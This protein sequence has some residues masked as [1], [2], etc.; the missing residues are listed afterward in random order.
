MENYKKHYCLILIVTFI[1][2]IC[3]YELLDSIRNFN[4]NPSLTL[5]VILVSQ[6]VKLP[7]EVD[8]ATNNIDFKILYNEKRTSLSKARNIGLDYLTEHSIQGDF[9]TFPDDDS[10]FDAHFFENFLKVVKQPNNYLI[11]VYNT[12]TKTLYKKFNIKNRSKLEYRHFK[13]VG[14]PNI[15]IS[16][17]TFKTGVRFDTDLGV[18][19]KYG[20]AE[21]NDFYFRC[22]NVEPFYFT[23][24]IYIFHRATQNRYAQMP[25][26]EI[27]KRFRGYSTG[28]I[29]VVLKYHQPVELFR[30]L[31]RT[32]G[33]SFVN[34][35][36][37][38]LKLSC[39]YF[40][41]FFLRI[42][43]IFQIWINKEYRDSKQ[44]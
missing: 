30:I 29:Y 7:T 37:G 21:D 33:A 24:D 14:P 34:I 18:G 36:K 8:T 28:Y 6:G 43:L 26:K 27:L 31:I 13:Y 23:N 22:Y 12:G 11:P 16:F 10:A 17:D 3:I 35:F 9:I 44:Q 40:V 41:Q 38:N 25:F 1:D 39:A 15:I 4:K 20:S 19:A 42:Q 5:L 2:D 32:A